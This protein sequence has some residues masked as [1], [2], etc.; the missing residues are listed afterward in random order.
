MLLMLEFM[1]SRF[2]IRLSHIAAFFLSVILSGLVISLLLQG[3]KKKV[4]EP[5]FR[6]GLH[7]DFN[8][9][10][11]SF[12]KRLPDHQHIPIIHALIFIAHENLD[13]DFYRGKNM[14]DITQLS[15]TDEQ[16]FQLNGTSV[17][18][19]LDI[20]HSQFNI[21]QNEQIKTLEVMKLRLKENKER[22]AQQL[23]EE[24]M[25]YRI[26]ANN[27][28]FSYEKGS[29]SINAYLTFDL[30]NES[31]LDINGVKFTVQFKDRASGQHYNKT[32]RTWSDNDSLK[33]GQTR[34]VTQTL[35][36][37]PNL[38]N[39]PISQYPTRLEPI[40]SIDNAIK[41][42]GELFRRPPNLS[43]ESK[44]IYLQSEVDKLETVLEKSKDRKK[45]TFW[46]IFS[47]SG[48]KP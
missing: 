9:H 1:E 4:E 48:V 44:I 7:S 37:C 25:L 27:V 35:S 36:N 42:D 41:V 23:Q 43:L 5:R 21:V 30:K 34:E 14:N 28:K 22:F 3:C 12:L 33:P 8:M 20:S 40:F 47:H 16:K 19:I 32:Q 39:V 17:S 29:F 15:F 10:V 26:K 46:A 45:F 11:E 38:G 24:E 31:A 13:P 6:V 2:H 18:D